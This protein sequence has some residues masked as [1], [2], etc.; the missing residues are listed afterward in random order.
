MCLIGSLRNSVVLNDGF[1]I[2]SGFLKWSVKFPLY[3]FPLVWIRTAY[4]L[5]QGERLISVGKSFY[6]PMIWTGFAGPPGFLSWVLISIID[7]NL[8]EE[9]GLILFL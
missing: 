2:F 5:L 4:I 3:H 8:E 9:F 7:G 6:F 1:M